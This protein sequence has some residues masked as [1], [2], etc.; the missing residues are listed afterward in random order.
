MRRIV[1]FILLIYVVFAK[2]TIGQERSLVD[3][4]LPMEPRSKLVSEGIWGDPNVLPRDTANG[5]EDATLK[6]WCYWDGKIVKDDNGKY[7]IYGCRWHHSYPHGRGW[8]EDSKGIHAVS[9]NIMGPYRDLGVLWPQWQ[10]GKG[11]NVIGLRMHD[12][13]YAAVTSEITN[14]EVFVS[15]NPYGP[16]ITS[17]NVCYTKLLRFGIYVDILSFVIPQFL[18]SGVAPS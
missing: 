18:I 7:H 14:G 2:S 8:K 11:S 1:C 4:F 12:G 6:E 9:D 3:F 5:L 16:R 10:N 13:R 17:Y 15:D